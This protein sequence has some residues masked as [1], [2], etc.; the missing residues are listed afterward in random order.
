MSSLAHA[1]VGW[2]AHPN[3]CEDAQH[4]C[5]ICD[6]WFCSDHGSPHKP[7]HQ[8]DDTISVCWKCGGYN[9]DE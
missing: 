2:C 5:E 1:P 3:C 7:Q 4:C 9:A 6:A 8:Y